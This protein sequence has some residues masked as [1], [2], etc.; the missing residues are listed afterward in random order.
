[1]IQGIIAAF[2]FAIVIS[3]IIAVLKKRHQKNIELKNAAPESFLA[4][5]LKCKHIKA[6]VRELI[7]IDL[8]EKYLIKQMN[9]N[10]CL[11]DDCYLAEVKKENDII[12]IT[13]NGGSQCASFSTALYIK[14]HKI[15]IHTKNLMIETWDI[16]SKK[17]GKKIYEGIEGFLKYTNIS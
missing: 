12:L 15:Y 4:S 11:F 8:L 13:S 2:L 17:V 5:V 14:D 10:S 9:E 16:F 1:M 6:E 7:T 3:V